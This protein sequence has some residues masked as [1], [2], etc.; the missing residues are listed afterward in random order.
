LPYS[1]DEHSAALAAVEQAG[2]VFSVAANELG[3]SRDRVRRVFLEATRVQA[4][5][6]LG[7]GAHKTLP[8]F[9]VSKVSTLHNRDGEAVAQWVQQKPE[10][11]EQ[12]AAF[13]E[14]IEAMVSDARE[15]LPP[16]PRPEHTDADLLALYP[17]GDPH[18]GM[19]S[20]A[21]ETGEN[22][23]LNIAE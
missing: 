22:F 15:V 1:P 2:G 14:A 16:V 3:W 21:K 8:G 20:W 5:G 10:A 9:G 4:E 18:F 19:L 17:M 6:T 12:E 11:A 23:D 13:R 7:H